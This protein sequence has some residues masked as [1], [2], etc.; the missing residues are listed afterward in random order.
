MGVIK[1][2][3]QIDRKILLSKD[4][5][6]YSRRETDLKLYMNVPS[7]RTGLAD[8]SGIFYYFFFKTVSSNDDQKGD[9]SI[10]SIVFYS[11]L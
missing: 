7:S 4:Y 9:W 11:I 10:F 2:S 1:L 5:L 6:K 8:L 3:F